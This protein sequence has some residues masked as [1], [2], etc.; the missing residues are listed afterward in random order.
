[1]LA[2]ARALASQ[3]RV[4]VVDEL[5]QGL[6]PHVVERLLATVRAAADRGV[7]VLLVE[8][9][10]PLALEIADRSYVLH[11]GRVVMQQGRADA[12]AAGEVE[13]AVISGDSRWVEPRPRG[14]F[15][16]ERPTPRSSA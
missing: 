10:I 9:R 3:P 11:L 14:V 15:I 7:G 16:V 6:A 1:M 4:L 8:Q 5:S 12:R 2:L 13:R